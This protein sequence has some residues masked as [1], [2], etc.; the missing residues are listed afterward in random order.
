[1]VKLDPVLPRVVTPPLRG[2]AGYG[3][4]RLCA[5]ASSMQKHICGTVCSTAAAAAR[6]Q[7]HNGRRVNSKHASQ[8]KHQGLAFGPARGRL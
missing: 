4:Y 2:T 6:Q 1:M 8:G 5:G 3:W 7:P